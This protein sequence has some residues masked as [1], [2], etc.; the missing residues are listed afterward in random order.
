MDSSRFAALRWPEYTRWGLRRHLNHESKLSPHASCSAAELQN[1]TLIFYNLAFPLVP[2]DTLSLGN[3]PL[4]ALITTTVN[5]VTQELLSVS[6]LGGDAVG[7]STSLSTPL[8]ATS[9]EAGGPVPQFYSLDFD[10]SN[11]LKGRVVQF[12]SAAETAF[13]PP[14][15]TVSF[16]TIPAEFNISRIPEPSTLA[17]IIGVVGAGFAR[18]L[19]RH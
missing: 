13:G 1:V 8:A 16:S 11:P 15:G 14:P 5:D 3:F 2:V 18:R 9:T 6:Y 12:I 19:R 7:L 10:T 17:L 4:A